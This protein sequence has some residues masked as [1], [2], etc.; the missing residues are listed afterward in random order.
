MKALIKNGTIITASEY[1]KADLLIED[2]K[3]ACIGTNIG[4][5]AD[6]KIDAQDKLIFPGGID[7][8]VHMNVPCS[9]GSLSAGYDTE[10]IAAALGGTTTILDYVL[11]EYGKSMHESIDGAHALAESQAA[12]DYGFH[13]IVTNP[14]EQTIAEIEDLIDSGITSFKLF[15]ANDLALDDQQLLKFMEELARL[16]GLACVHAENG[17]IISSLQNGH[18]KKKQLEPYYHFLSRPLISE[19]EAINRAIALAKTA[20]CSMLVA[21]VSNL[22]GVN[23]ITG[24]QAPAPIH[25]ESCP[26][27]LVL[28]DDEYRQGEFGTAKYVISPPLRSKEE[29][30]R[31][32]VG[33]KNRGIDIISSDHNGFNYSTHKQLGKDDYTLIPNGG[34]GIEQRFTLMYHTLTER[35]I[36]L[37]R[38]VDLIAT[39]PAKIFGLFPQKGTIAPGSDADL[40]IFDPA[41]EW[42]I[43]AKE[44][45]QASDYTSYEGLRMKGR[46][47]KV[48]LRG[49]LIVDE[50][51]YVG[52]PGDGKFIARQTLKS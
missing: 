14:D 39:K 28:D 6:V 38:F 8:H 20:K 34:P 51:K 10:T 17:A 47:D 27:Y 4:G 3:I 35:G 41:I 44:Q 22:E 42:T 37:S 23:I 50:G 29:K 12:I 9:D 33:I 19:N 16:G 45:H 18:K 48:L 24:A 26:H 15:M 13:V 11:Q 40:V 21:H 1:I 25:T 46:V 7:A 43:T 2:G 30:E 5:E 49:E 31:L 52:E 32:W 36:D